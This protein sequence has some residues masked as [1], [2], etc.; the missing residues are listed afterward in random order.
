MLFIIFIQLETKLAQFIQ[1][2][3]LRGDVDIKSYEK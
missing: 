1:Y 3:S 2:K